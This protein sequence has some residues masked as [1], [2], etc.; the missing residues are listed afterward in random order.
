MMRGGAYLF[1]YEPLREH[2]ALSHRQ[3]LPSQ[4]EH[5]PADKHDGPALDGSAKRE[6]DLSREDEQREYYEAEG[7]AEVVDDVTSEERQHDIG[8]AINR[9]QESVVRLEIGGGHQLGEGVVEG[10]GVVEAVIVA[11]HHQAGEEA[12]SCVWGIGGGG[13]WG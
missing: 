4:T 12:A 3:V 2:G 11:D 7:R 10:G 5:H 1:A 8:D 9:V 6:H 13:D